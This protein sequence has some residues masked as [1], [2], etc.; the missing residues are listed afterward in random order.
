MAHPMNSMLQRRD[1]GVARPRSAMQPHSSI[2]TH[3]VC[4]NPSL[5]HASSSP[6]SG[7]AP[8]PEVAPEP[9]RA[10]LS[11]LPVLRSQ[12]SACG[13][14]TALATGNHGNQVGAP[15]LSPL[16]LVVTLVNS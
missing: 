14:L 10:R 7:R 3:T 12:V 4:I 16:T 2:H 15:L 8:E 5:P 1:G 6:A 11:V 9:D 13:A